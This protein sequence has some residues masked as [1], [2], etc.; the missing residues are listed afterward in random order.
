M[1]HQVQIISVLCMIMNRTTVSVTKLKDALKACLQ[2]NSYFVF[3][4][5]LKLPLI[6]AYVIHQASICDTHIVNLINE[7]FYNNMHL[8][9]LK[10]ES[11]TPPAFTTYYLHLHVKIYRDPF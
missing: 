6:K 5:L 9:Y 2:K 4:Q 1:G 11:S 10:C 7:F 3:V 8:Y